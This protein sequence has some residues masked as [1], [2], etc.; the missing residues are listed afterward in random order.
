MA[1]VRS[2]GVFVAND[3][4]IITDRAEFTAILEHDIKLGLPPP[5]SVS[6]GLMPGTTGFSPPRS[7]DDLSCQGAQVIAAKR[8]NVDTR[9]AM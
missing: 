8:A 5:L 9:S 4:R 1:F 7:A 6:L 2:G 3:G